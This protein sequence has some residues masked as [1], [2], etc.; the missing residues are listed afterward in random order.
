[1]DSTSTPSAAE[2]GSQIA[3]SQ[4]QFT[5]NAKEY[6]G[7]WIVNILLTL[8][9]LGIYSAWATVRTKQYFYGHTVLDGHRFDYLATPIQILKGRL[10]AVGLFVIY[11]VVSGYFP[12]VGALLALALALL[13]PWMINQG[14]KFSMRMTRYRNIRFAFKG[15][16]GEAMVNFVVLPFFSIFTLYLLMPW[17]LKRIDAYIHSNIRYGDKPVHVQ[18]Q[19]KAYYKAALLVVLLGILMLVALGIVL[20][21][22]TGVGMNP[23]DIGSSQFVLVLIVP[24]YLFVISALQG[25]YQAQI[26]N[27]ILNNAQ[28]EDVAEFKSNLQPQRYAL[29]LATNAAAIVLTAGLAFPWAKVRKVKA[30][31]GA[32][33]VVLLPG[34]D[35]VLDNAQQADSSFAEEAANVFDV[36]ISLT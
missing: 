2:P 15:N 7:I 21:L 34:A 10:L 19:G 18:L 13:V 14:L 17:V 32:T 29:I 27:H 8:L 36:D 20:S 25:I 23:D 9:T 31:A 4:L 22:V 1:M 33:Q 16:F 35:Q 5:G 6:F 28:I 26:R 3:P 30:L 11:S 24:L 12:L